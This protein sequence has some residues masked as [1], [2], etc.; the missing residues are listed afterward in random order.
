MLD[1]KSYW[2]CK[3][4]KIYTNCKHCIAVDLM[5]KYSQNDSSREG[6]D[7]LY[8]QV[9]WNRLCDITW[10]GVVAAATTKGNSKH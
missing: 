8:F 10:R 9:A 3:Y 7:T 4:P 5:L 2:I 6:S 1:M